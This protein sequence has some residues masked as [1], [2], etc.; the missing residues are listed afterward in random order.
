MGVESWT[1]YVLYSLDLERKSTF[2]GQ[3]SFI[4]VLVWKCRRLVTIYLFD[5][6]AFVI[7]SSETGQLM[8][9]K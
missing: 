8:E 9:R 3:S 6:L 1:H 2:L 4:T 5:V 7:L